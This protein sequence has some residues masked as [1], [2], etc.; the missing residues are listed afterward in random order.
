MSKSHWDT[1][2]GATGHMLVQVVSAK[3]LGIEKPTELFV[4]PLNEC[5]SRRVPYVQLSSIYGQWFF[6]VF[7]TE[8]GYEVILGLGL[9][10][11]VCDRF[12]LSVRASR[13]KPRSPKRS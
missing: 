8:Y 2:L 5:Q 11:F 12:A 6:I 13:T 7:G 1:S 10:T 3:G 9:L 4:R